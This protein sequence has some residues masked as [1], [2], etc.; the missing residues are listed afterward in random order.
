MF[1]RGL[2]AAGLGLLLVPATAHAD[3]LDFTVNE[4][5]VPGSAGF[6]P[7]AG[8]DYVNP[9][10]ADKLNGSY[11][12][13]LTFSG[14]PGSGTV[15][16][17][18]SAYADFG[19]YLSNE[20]SVD[21]TSLLTTG[22]GVD[23]HQYSLYALFSATGTYDGT[24]FTGLSAE[25]HFFLDPNANTVESFG[26][27]A[28]G[29]TA[30]TVIGNGEDIEIMSANNL[31]SGIG[32]DSG[33]A[34]LFDFE[35]LNPVLT[36]FGKTYWPSLPLVNIISN[37]DGD[38]DVLVPVATAPGFTFNTS[39]DV[40]NVFT[41]TAVPEPATLTLLGFGLAGVRWASRRRKGNVTA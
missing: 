38:L 14:V 21:V 13:R 28:T 32:N 8:S 22:S 26:P 33:R 20:G 7:P 10:V 27:T 11:T 35:F 1:M 39:G 30:P 4:A 18:S 29:F 40:S 17:T 2:A 41:A 3:F 23:S 37:P 36:A 31:I 5:V 6:V 16:F 9:F 19:Q 24:A 12:E 34:G 25:I 15:S